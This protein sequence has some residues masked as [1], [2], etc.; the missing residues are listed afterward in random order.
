MRRS[1]LSVV[2]RQQSAA[3]DCPGV[4]GCQSLMDS[5][6]MPEPFAS[7]ACCSLRTSLGATVHCTTTDDNIRRD[8][9]GQHISPAPR[10]QPLPSDIMQRP[11]HLTWAVK[12]VIPS[13]L[14]T[15]AHPMTPAA[16]P[17]ST[18]MKPDAKSVADVH[19]PRCKMGSFSSQYDVL[20]T[21]KTFA[22]AL[23]SRASPST[24]T[25]SSC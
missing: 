12:H 20:C 1:R 10:C 3:G 14:Q 19:Q 9:A 13:I 5:D 17:P 8:G 25:P 24:C 22:S 11:W 2:L 6:R 4:R 16:R 7:R 21:Q 23:G 15:S 18:E